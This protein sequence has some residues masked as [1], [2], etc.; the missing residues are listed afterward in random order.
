[1]PI[2]V[3]FSEVQNFEPVP[4]GV[5]TVRVASIEDKQAGENAQNPGAPML[6]WS[7]E[8]TEPEEFAGRRIFNNTMLSGKALF[9]LRNTLKALDPENADEYDGEIEF[10]P[11]DFINKECVIEVSQEPYN[12]RMT[13][14]IKKFMPL[15]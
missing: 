3:D 11:E 8:V 9:N 7:F 15:Y 4:S 13:N 2:R 14:R 5:Y 1:M 10:E 12:D 6:L